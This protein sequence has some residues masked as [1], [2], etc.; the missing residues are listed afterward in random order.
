VKKT[1]VFIDAL[2][3]SEIVATMLYRNYNCC[4]IAANFSANA[5]ELDLDKTIM[6]N[7]TFSSAQTMSFCLET[8]LVC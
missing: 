1:K 2:N 4:N 6:V 8:C 7:P 5:K 3:L